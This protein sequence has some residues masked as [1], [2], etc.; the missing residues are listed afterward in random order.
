M[1]T[2][3]RCGSKI[4]RHARFNLSRNFFYVNLLLSVRGAEYEYGMANYELADYER[5]GNRIIRSRRRRIHSR[6]HLRLAGNCFAH[7]STIM[8]LGSEI[9][10]RSVSY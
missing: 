10:L 4:L 6:Q 9:T 5:I 7:C 8:P 1:L 2:V 3:S